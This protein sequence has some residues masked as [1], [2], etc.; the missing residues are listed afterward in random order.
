[1]RPAELATGPPFHLRQRA[2][3]DGFLMLFRD[4]VILCRLPKA[5]VGLRFFGRI[6][7]RVLARTRKVMLLRWVPQ[8]SPR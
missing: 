1:M 2:N 4:G 6:C 8:H 7:N 5:R 3:L